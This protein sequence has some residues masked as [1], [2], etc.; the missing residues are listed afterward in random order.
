MEPQMET[1][2]PDVTETSSET[3]L[4]A[5]P[6]DASSKETET[7]VTHRDIA[8][9]HGKQLVDRDGEKI[10]KLEDVYFDIETDEPQF[11]TVK[12]GLIARHLTFVPLA[13]ITIGPDNLQVSVSKK[14]V[15]DAPIIQQEGDE[16]SQ[17]DESA[18]YHHYQ[19]NYTASD[20][21]SGRRL[22]RR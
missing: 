14:Q 10:G 4:P 2:E 17:A 11:G 12:E 3:P 9:W 20:T 13:E 8:E 15:K 1:D 21:P 16:L 6:S 22:A 5:S 18:L 19:L 7:T